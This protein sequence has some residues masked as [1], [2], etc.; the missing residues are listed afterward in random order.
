MATISETEYQT[1][2]RQLERLNAELAGQLDRQASMV[3][4]A[5]KWSNTYDDG[6]DDGLLLE[7]VTEYYGTM[8]AYEAAKE[9]G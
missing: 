9:Q 2:I 7:S 8:A 5:C 3:A 6:A 4:A 1:R